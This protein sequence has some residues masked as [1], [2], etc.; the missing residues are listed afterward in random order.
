MIALTPAGTVPDAVRADADRAPA[1]GTGWA[2]R[3]L[4]VGVVALPPVLLVAAAWHARV[5]AWQDAT[6]EMSR[7]ADTAAEYALRVL[8]G[9]KLRL[10]HANDL[11]A[12]LT[13]P[14]VRAEERR[15][16]EALARIAGQEA[17]GGGSLNI[18]AFDRE[19]FPLVAANTHPVPRELS[20]ADRDFNQAL[21][22]PLA[23]EPY[24]SRVEIGRL[25]GRAYF[26]IARRRTGSANPWARDGYDGVV[27]VTVYVDRASAALRNLA[28]DPS[29]AVT[30]VRSD[31]EVLA[32]SLGFGAHGPPLR[33]GA[34]SPMLEAMARGEKRAVIRA[35]STI[36]GVR[37]IAAYRQVEGWPV[38]VSAARSEAA[39]IGRWW[40]TVAGLLAVGLPA[41]ALLLAM[42]AAVWRRQRAL[43]QANLELDRRVAERTSELAARTAALAESEARLRLAQGAAHIGSFEW[44]PETGE[45]RFSPEMHALLGLD[46]MRDG[47]LD[48][49]RFLALVHPG[50]RAAVVA[51][52]RGAPG[53][54]SHEIEF[55]VLRRS[56]TA[57]DGEGAAE[58]RWLLGRGR[59]LPGGGRGGQPGR[60][61]GVMLDI[62]ERR[63]A[64]ERRDLV[65]REVAHR[66]RNTLQLVAAAIRMTRARDAAEF[67]R[68]LEARVAALSRAQALVAASGGHGT[69]LSALAEGELD[70]LQGSA[71][72]AAATVTLSG[73]GF[74]V[75]E[76]AVQP[77]SMALHELATNAAKYG[78]LSAPGGRVALSWQVDEA[79][80][81]LRLRWEESGGPPVAA[82]PERAGFGSRVIEATLARQLGGTLHQDWRPQGLVLEAE[83]PLSVLRAG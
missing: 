80:G 32:R 40:G 58:E 30:L 75:A 27:E 21:R 64:E 42:T 69:E 65:A 6:A 8:E 43:A 46:A 50:D 10:G 24:V 53:A 70:A 76:G 36:D 63:Q 25:T 13:D 57:D 61:V 77:L 55:R 59:W 39:V 19:G 31:G 68:L 18:F 14:A 83:L 74:V 16:H 17:D 3:A 79:A 56:L 52:I 41:W 15:L 23:P 38:H 11:L 45:S 35:R 72:G 4:L 28:Q 33:L 54:G 62:T 34:D 48:L 44:L 20:F 71:A 1:G 60:V 66:A 9:H 73:P 49:A 26:A 12:G 81:L 82:P 7:T 67:A 22:D 5:A 37:R 51:A 78:A 29:D 2:L 47:P